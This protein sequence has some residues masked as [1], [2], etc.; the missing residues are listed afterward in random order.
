MI[1]NG[2]LIEIDYSCRAVERQ[3]IAL[4]FASEEFKKTKI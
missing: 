4:T 3:I 2:L 1:E